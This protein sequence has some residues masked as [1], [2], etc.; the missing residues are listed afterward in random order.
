MQL[1]AGGLVRRARC[2]AAPG[3]PASFIDTT[4]RGQRRYC[5]GACSAR[6]RMHR[7][8]SSGIGGAGPDPLPLPGN[9]A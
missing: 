9:R 8:R 2:C 3:C 4:K 5:S 7:R 6:L 1:H